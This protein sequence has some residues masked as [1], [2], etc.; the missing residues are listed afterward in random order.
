MLKEGATEFKLDFKLPAFLTFATA[1]IP[2]IFF[3]WF[4]QVSYGNPFQ[5]SATVPTVKAID[6]R[7]LPTTPQSA[8]TEVIE[9]F[10]NPELQDKSLVR[11]FKSRNIL[12][13]FYIHFL[14][15]DR[16][17]IYYTPV[18]LF[19]V[20]AILP[21]YKK[22]SRVLALLLSII[23]MGILLY[24]MWG[25]PWGGWAFGS[26]YLIPAYA[27]F[28][29][30]LAVTLD[31]IKKNIFLSLLFFALLCY[32]ISVNSLGALTSNRNPPQAEVL[33]LEELSGVEQKYTYE[34]NY[35]FLYSNR[36]KS[37]VYQTFLKDYLYAWEYYR[38]ITFTIIGVAGLLVIL[39]NVE[40]GYIGGENDKS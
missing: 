11:F 27:L 1:G 5:L 37:Y 22:N 18:I 40:K 25:D 7:G 8:G 29:I 14:S 26:R 31:N 32:S 33:A 30:L 9:R 23:G 20:F 34:R 17:I 24:S 6:E 21:L 35:D 28:S 4:N 10:V 36:S 19:A 13:G 16:G 2:L 15:P 39:L 38:L 12:N 3:L